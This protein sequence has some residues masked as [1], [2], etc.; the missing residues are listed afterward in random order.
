[1]DM[2]ELSSNAHK[3]QICDSP[4]F[5]EVHYEHSKKLACTHQDIHE[6]SPRRDYIC[7]KEV[8]DFLVRMELLLIPN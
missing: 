1:M 4:N 8:A 7:Y 2:I 6:R 5:L 3:L